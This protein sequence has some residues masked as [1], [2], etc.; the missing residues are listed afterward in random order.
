MIMSS[1]NQKPIPL[2]GKR[3]KMKNKEIKIPRVIKLSGHQQTH[4]PGT[5]HLSGPDAG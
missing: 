5:S 2:S 1:Q 3:T 4:L